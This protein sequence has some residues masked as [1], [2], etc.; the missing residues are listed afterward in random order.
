[1]LGR[2]ISKDKIR[3]VEEKYVL[4]KTV[5]QAEREEQKA[6]QKAQKERQK[7]AEMAVT[8]E[9]VFNEIK[10][11]GKISVTQLF[12]KFGGR[13]EILLQRLET[14]VNLDRITFKNGAKNSK[15]YYVKA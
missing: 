11:A 9:K 3:L 5:K 13:K 14:L 7:E 15:M 8:L 10:K 1:V 12:L 6:E 2:L 4:A